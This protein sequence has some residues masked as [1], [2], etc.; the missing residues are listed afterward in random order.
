MLKNERPIGYQM[1]RK[2]F[3]GILA[4]RSEAEKKQNPYQYV[5]AYL[6]EQNNLRGKVTSLQVVDV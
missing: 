4:M 3:D 6:N 1:S 5:M 2:M